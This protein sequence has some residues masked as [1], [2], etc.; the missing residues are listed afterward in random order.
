MTPERKA[1]VGID[2]LL[3]A[4]GTHVCDMAQA[5]VHPAIGVA[6]REFPL[7]SGFGFAGYP[8][9]VNGLDS[10]PRT[11]VV[12]AL[13]GPEL[14][15]QWW[16]YLSGQATYIAAQESLV[17]F[18]AWLQQ[19]RMS[20]LPLEGQIPTVA[21][22]DHHLPII[23]KVEADGDITPHCAQALPNSVLA[24]SFEGGY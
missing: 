3:V 19:I 6:I 2:A 11:G 5:N 23:P 21:E 7:S 14:L 13:S 8:L 9:Y 20:L 22:V 12:F 4:A 18:L 24:R 1:R 10:E 17:T 16:T 15:V